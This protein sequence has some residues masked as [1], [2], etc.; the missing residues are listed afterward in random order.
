VI[1][2][3][4]TVFLTCCCCYPPA[5]GAEQ[6]E[7]VSQQVERLLARHPQTTFSIHFCEA[8]SG[9]TIYAHQSHTPLI[10]AS[11]IKIITTAAAVDQLGGDFVYETLIGLLGENLAVIGSGDPLTGD[12][13]LAEEKSQ[14]IYHIF[15]QVLSALQRREINELSGDLLIDNFI[16][17]DERF[18]PSWSAS[19]AN[20]WYA[21]QV[22]AVN[23]N[24]NCV[25]FILK[26]SQRAGALTR[27]EMEPIWPSTCWPEK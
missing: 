20:R 24:D 25:D 21:A 16:F 11:N 13:V 4:L 18:H 15:Q 26:P 12:A 22:S 27:Y 9:R 3:F 8:E 19:E 17:D 7:A 1:R 2:R 6:S 14:D 5:L 10:P 23:F